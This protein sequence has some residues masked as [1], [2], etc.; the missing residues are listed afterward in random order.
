M[1]HPNICWASSFA[2]SP[3][4]SLLQLSV[5]LLTRTRLSC[6][7]QPCY[8]SSSLSLH[9]FHLDFFRSF[10]LI[11][12]GPDFNPSSLFSMHLTIIV[13]NADMITSASCLT[14]AHGPSSHIAMALN[15]QH[16]KIY[17]ESIVN[18]SWGL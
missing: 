11:S 14:L 18:L 4:S 1:C 16:I 15:W 8:H 5:C 6:P 10:L 9:I 17:I 3:I 2:S 7:F 12:L 13:F